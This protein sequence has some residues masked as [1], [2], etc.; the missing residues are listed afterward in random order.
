MSLDINNKSGAKN[1]QHNKGPSTSLD[2]KKSFASDYHEDSKVGFKKR[3]KP[4]QDLVSFLEEA[5]PENHLMS[6]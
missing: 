5:A 2:F 4:P 1:L 3:A 6:K